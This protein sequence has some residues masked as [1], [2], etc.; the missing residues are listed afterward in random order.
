VSVTVKSLA[1]AAVEVK[2]L[3]VDYTCFLGESEKLDGLQTMISP[4]T[5]T[6]P[7]TLSSGFTD[8]TNKKLT[9]LI[10]G[11][12]TNTDYLLQ[13]VVRTNEGQVKRDNIGLRIVP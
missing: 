10:A 12:K 4:F 11:G 8:A 2:R 7:V 13:L 5:V 3:Y 6:A 9:L 1:K